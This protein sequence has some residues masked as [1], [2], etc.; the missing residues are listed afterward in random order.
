ML[1]DTKYLSDLLLPIS[2]I[3][4]KYEHMAKISGGNYNIF[5]ILRLTDR[6]ISHSRIIANL[7]NPR[8]A[9]AQ[10]DIF[11]RLFLEALK[12]EIK[13]NYENMS[14]SQ[15]F[16]II[17]YI[18]DLYNTDV[19]IVTEKN[20]GPINNDEKTGGI[21]DIVM[22]GSS[23]VIFIENKIHASDQESQLLRYHNY[24][25]SALLLYLTLDGR[26]ASTKS[27]GGSENVKYYRISYKHT[28]LNWLE[29]CKIVSIDK[30]FIRETL[31]QYIN[32]IKH[33]TGQPRSK[34]MNEEIIK[35]VVNDELKL[36][37]TVSLVKGFESLKLYLLKEFIKRFAAY[38]EERISEKLDIEYLIDDYSKIKSSNEDLNLF[39]IKNSDEDNLKLLF[40]IRK[41][42]GLIFGITTGLG[43][44]EKN[45]S[46]E[47]KKLGSNFTDFD[48]EV[49]GNFI[50]FKKLNINFSDLS[51]N[52]IEKINLLSLNKTIEDLYQETLDML[53][54]FSEL[55]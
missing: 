9:H 25:E 17:R 40:G 23:E 55:P 32:I 46:P 53:N 47:Y 12:D 7:L 41:S 43:E 15:L 1:M 33:L 37:A 14:D 49:P 35:S 13:V 51:D 38:Y 10:G 6:E 44:K 5:K 28:I 36:K 20:I 27:L 22:T 54:K 45:M 18:D 21:I 19:R 8:G 30:P 24:N 50:R 31:S 11:F 34:E 3:I 39:Y 42:Y 52:D 16:N 4:T 2:G 29:N 48:L 26:E